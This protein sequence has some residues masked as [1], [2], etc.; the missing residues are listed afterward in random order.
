MRPLRYPTLWLS[1]GWLMLVVIA[2]AMAVPTPNVDVAIDYADKWV[3]VLAF[4]TLAGWTAQIYRPSPALAWR[5]LGLLA[6]AA[7]TELMQA[8]IPW[9]SG[10]WGDFIADALGVAL[11][12]ALAYGPGGRGLLRVEKLMASARLTQ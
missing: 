1:I 11:G 12:L 6:F 4:A 8:I 9:R 10:D 7:A 2:I 3:H 5:G